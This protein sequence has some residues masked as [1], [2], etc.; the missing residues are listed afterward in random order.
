MNTY[1]LS[2]DLATARADKF[3][4]DQTARLFSSIQRSPRKRLK[5]RHFGAVNALDIEQIN[6]R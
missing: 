2:R 4:F 5:K 1:L 6:G 3:H